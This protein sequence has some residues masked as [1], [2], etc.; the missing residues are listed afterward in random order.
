V[1]LEALEITHVPG[2]RDFCIGPA[3]EVIEQ[4]AG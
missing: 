3:I 2:E 4:E 1:K